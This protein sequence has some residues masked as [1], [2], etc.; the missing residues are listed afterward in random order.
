[1]AKHPLNSGPLGHKCRA[2][3]EDPCTSMQKRR[4]IVQDTSNGKEN[5]KFNPLKPS[6]SIAHTQ[7]TQFRLALEDRPPP[8]T[9]GHPSSIA[10]NARS[11]NITLNVNTSLTIVIRMENVHLRLLDLPPEILQLITQSVESSD[12]LK[13]FRLSCKTLDK[14]ATKH[15]FGEFVLV[16]HKLSLARFEKQA[17]SP[18]AKDLECLILDGR[19]LL[20]DNHYALW[21]AGCPDN[22]KVTKDEIDR[23]IASMQQFRNLKEFSVQAYDPKSHATTPIPTFIKQLIRKTGNRPRLI[24]FDS[25]NI[26]ANLLCA[27]YAC[28]IKLRRLTIGGIHPEIFENENVPDNLFEVL[29]SDL[30]DLSL[31]FQ[32]EKW[33]EDDSEVEPTQHHVSTILKSCSKLRSLSIICSEPGHLKHW[34]MKPTFISPPIRCPELA[35]LSITSHTGPMND[36]LEILAAVAPSLR[37]LRL[38]ELWL[39]TSRQDEQEPE[40]DDVKEVRRT[41]WVRVLQTVRDTMNLQSFDLAG[42]LHAGRYQGFNLARGSDSAYFHDPPVRQEVIEWVLQKREMCQLVHNATVDRFYDDFADFV[43]FDGLLTWNEAEY[44]KGDDSWA[45]HWREPWWVDEVADEEVDD[46]MVAEEDEQEE[47][48]DEEDGREGE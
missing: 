12:D 28:G 1:M 33:F 17:K 40:Q 3:T 13:N 2:S 48:G 27:M 38:E 36:F 21:T 24:V 25:Q 39:Q 45:V 5:A 6:T 37:S 20:Y 10:K 18:R 30:T 16:A 35:H 11:N 43:P 26:T 31:E 15:L 42:C 32:F 7:P 8:R 29:G 23:F 9:S 47:D 41:C 4:A 44:W 22:F 19:T 34:L 46:V 14:A